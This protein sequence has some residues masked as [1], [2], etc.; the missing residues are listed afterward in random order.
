MIDVCTIAL[1]SG[2][3]SGVI[4][5]VGKEL[6]LRHGNNCNYSFLGIFRN[7]DV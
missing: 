7:S 2:F 5:A 1:V 4:L 6:R 3:I